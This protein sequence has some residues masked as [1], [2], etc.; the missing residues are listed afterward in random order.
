VLNAKGESTVH[1]L[2]MRHTCVVLSAFVVLASC[3]TQRSDQVDVPDGQIYSTSV[4]VGKCAFVQTEEVEK[5]LPAVLAA[6]ASGV[7]S[8]G[9]NRFGEALTAA[10]ESKEW[11]ALGARNFEASKTTFPNCIQIAR[12]LFYTN[13]ADTIITDQET[14][15][16]LDNKAATPTDWSR[17]R[18][19]ILIGNGLWFAD[20]P[21]FFFE[22]I[23]RGSKNKQALTVE[24]VITRLEAPIGTRL[25]RPRRSR[26]VAIFAAFHEPGKA[27]D[28]RK[29]PSASLVLGKLRPGQPRSDRTTVDPWSQVVPASMPFESPWFS[30]SMTETAAPLTASVLVTESESANEFLAFLGRVFSEQGTKQALTTALENAL[31]PEKREA[32][33]ASARETETNARNEADQTYADAIAKLRLCAAAKDNVEK[34]G[35]DAREAMRNAN[36]KAAVIGENDRFPQSSIDKIN[37]RLP[38]PS[39]SDACGA[40]YTS[41]H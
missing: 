32:A 35:S 28:L 36:L 39:I 17:E 14:W 2:K 23:F 38:P 1:F 20:R 31:I 5:I 7:I 29:N 3:T 9:V 18:V 41:L 22:G 30:L 37:L 16:P 40:V 33:E 4:A 13:P 11:Q 26:E 15:I 34:A 10:G 8:Q 19:N 24:P 27:P 21:D 6:I 25:L 12:G